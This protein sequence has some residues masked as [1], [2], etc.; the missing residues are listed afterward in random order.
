MAKSNNSL[1]WMPFLTLSNTDSFASHQRDADSEIRWAHW[2]FC[3]IC[4]I[5]LNNANIPS[6]K[7]LIALLIAKE[8]KIPTKYSDFFKYFLGRKNFDLTEGN[9]DKSI[10][11]QAVERSST[12]L[13]AYLLPKPGRARNV[14]TYIET[15]LANGFIWP[16]KSPV[17]ALILFVGKPDNNFHLCVDYWG[18]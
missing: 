10:R 7:G 18:Q 17:D 15:N 16:S 2:S 14:E 12:T 6:L 1:I 4:N 11:Y 3:D 5:S 9:Q 8:V 13:W